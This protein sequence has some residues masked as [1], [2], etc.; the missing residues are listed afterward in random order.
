MKLDSNGEGCSSPLGLLPRLCVQQLIA[1]KHPSRDKYT[2]ENA[3]SISVEVIDGQLVELSVSFLSRRGIAYQASELNSIRR[4]LVAGKPNR[5]K[6]ISW[7][8]QR[9]P[10]S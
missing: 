2:F 8:D 7:V 9:Y 5:T 10:K 6:K 4:V 3:P 1:I